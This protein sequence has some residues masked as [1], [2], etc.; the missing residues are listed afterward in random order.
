MTQKSLVPYDPEKLARDKARVEDGFWDKLRRYAR[1]VPFAEEAVVV[2]YCAI[3]PATPLQVR[4]VLYGALAYFVLPFD[5][6]PDLVPLLGFTDD[7]AILYAAI[8][9]VTPHITDRHRAR[10]R[11]AL[12]DTDSG[13]TGADASPRSSETAT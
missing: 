3:D 2:Y 9:T 10:A 12:A 4:A 8:R 7:A 1:R 11:D 13:D 5:V 6:L